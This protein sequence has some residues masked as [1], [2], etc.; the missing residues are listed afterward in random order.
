MGKIRKFPLSGYRSVRKRG[1]KRNMRGLLYPRLLLS[2][3]VC[4]IHGE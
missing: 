3:G 4:Q 2:R 1:G